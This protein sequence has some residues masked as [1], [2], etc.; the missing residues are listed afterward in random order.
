MQFL[1]PR[2]ANNDAISISLPMQYEVTLL[3]SRSVFFSLAGKKSFMQEYML[4]HFIKISIVGRGD[5]HNL[6][7][8]CVKSAQVY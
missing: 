5:L 1:Q 2:A 4:L 3:F 8:L 6:G 7:L